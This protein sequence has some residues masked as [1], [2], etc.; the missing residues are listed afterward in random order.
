M[1]TPIDL[2]GF[3][4]LLS[5]MAALLL[6]L[7]KGNPHR[8][9]FVR[10]TVPTDR[11]IPES[12]KIDKPGQYLHYNVEFQHYLAGGGCAKCGAVY[13]YPGWNKT[14]CKSP[15]DVESVIYGDREQ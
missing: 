1:Y 14:G 10:E 6:C 7:R 4:G 3:M 13:F 5:G 2:L 11:T 9:R 12:W 8:S 15:G